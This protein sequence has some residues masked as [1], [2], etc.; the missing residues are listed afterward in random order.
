MKSRKRTL[1]RLLTGV[2]GYWS[3]FRASTSVL[4]SKAAYFSSH[5]KYRSTFVDTRTTQSQS[6]SQR[7]SCGASCARRNDF[8][9]NFASPLYACCPVIM[10][11][12]DYTVRFIVIFTHTRRREAPRLSHRCCHVQCMAWPEIFRIF[13][14]RP[15]TAS[16]AVHTASI[17]SPPSSSWNDWAT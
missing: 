14:R 1:P 10:V 5:Y 13:L 17:Q 16:L 4:N 2:T 7:H 12:S 6:S 15:E 11:W 8:A 9:N 3:I